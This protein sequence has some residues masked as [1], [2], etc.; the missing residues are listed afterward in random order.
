[1]LDLF[2]LLRY[3]VTSLLIIL[4]LLIGIPWL[5]YQYVRKEPKR[6]FRYNIGIF[7]AVIALILA[8]LVLFEFVY[9]TPS[10]PFRY[11]VTVEV[12]TPDGLKSG[13]SVMDAEYRVSGYDLGNLFDASFEGE[14]VFVDLGRGKNLVLTL[15]SEG[16]K[17]SNATSAS[18]LPVYVFDLPW[19]RGSREATLTGMPGAIERARKAGPTDIPLDILPLMATLENPLDRASARVVDPA[20]LSATFGDGYELARIMVA[21]S[22]EPINRDLSLK[23]TFLALSPDPATNLWKE[24]RAAGTRNLAI[25]YY[26]ERIR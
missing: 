21:T 16:S 5:T 2:I 4:A 26:R 3:I 7:T 17:S 22:S 11:K 19:F 14:A 9:Y 12:Q 1:M 18:L 10:F 24:D 15:R 6:P 13:S 8:P 23:L 20:N 25:S